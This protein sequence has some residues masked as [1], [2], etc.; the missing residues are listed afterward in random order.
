MPEPSTVWITISPKP[1]NIA[2]KD[3]EPVVEAAVSL[4]H[5]DEAQLI[6]LVT[7]AV[8]RLRDV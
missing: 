5:L 7:A 4:D 1:I 6:N 2:V 3:K 8:K